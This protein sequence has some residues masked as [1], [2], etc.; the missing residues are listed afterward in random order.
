MAWRI[1]NVVNGRIAE[2][3]VHELFK[4]LDFEV[5]PYGYEQTVTGLTYS[6]K[7][8]KANKRSKVQSKIANMPDFVVHHQE[9]GTFFIVVQVLYC[10]ELLR[11]LSASS[12][13]STPWLLLSISYSKSYQ[14]VCLVLTSTKLLWTSLKRV[15]GIRLMLGCKRLNPSTVGI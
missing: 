15:C 7:K 13:T 2:E 3:L 11:S 10:S 4:E 14:I 1:P 6:L 8:I 12:P 9:K 5:Y